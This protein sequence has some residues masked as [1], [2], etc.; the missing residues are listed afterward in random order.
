MSIQIE[1]NIH[2]LQSLF[3]QMSFM[4][5]EKA[6][7]KLLAIEIWQLKNFN[8]LKSKVFTKILIHK[9]HQNIKITVTAEEILVIKIY[10]SQLSHTDDIQLL[11]ILGKIHQKSLLF[12]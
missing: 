11:N 12:T 5:V 4:L 7:K 6:N 2:E 8:K 10:F 1:T 9:N 3:N